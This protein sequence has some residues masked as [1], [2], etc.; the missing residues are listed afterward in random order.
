[1][2]W[3]EKMILKCKVKAI[4]ILRQSLDLQRYTKKLCKAWKPTSENIF[5]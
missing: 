1:M 3:T 4:H 2:K 5:V